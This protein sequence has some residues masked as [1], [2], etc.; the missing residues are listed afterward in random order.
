MK[1]IPK[2]SLSQKPNY[3]KLAE[4]MDFYELFQKIEQKFNICFIFDSLGEEEKFSRY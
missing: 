1:K 2:I 3:I 4:D